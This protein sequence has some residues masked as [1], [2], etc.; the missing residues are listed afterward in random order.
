MV[1][2]HQEVRRCVPCCGRIYLTQ[3]GTV[4]IPGQPG[5]TPTPTGGIITAIPPAPTTVTPGPGSPSPVATTAVIGDA[6]VVLSIQLAAPTVNLNAGPLANG[7]ALRKR[8]AVVPTGELGYI[9]DDGTTGACS[10]AIQYELVNGG[11]V[12]V[13]TNVT[14][15][16]GVDLQT[17]DLNDPV[18]GSI[19]TTFS[20]SGGILVWTNEQFYNNTAVFCVLNSMLYASFT[21][22]G[23]PPGC[24]RVNLVAV[25][26][27]CS[28]PPYLHIF[29]ELLKCCSECLSECCR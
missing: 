7:T 28:P 14:I 20:V 8:Q 3:A 17:I 13:D 25:Q 21:E 24:T 15:A 10:S 2:F 16:A 12:D 1:V 27:S 26:G 18:G 29:A 5:G 23:S 19:F 11:L 22:N 4:T 9:A 6:T